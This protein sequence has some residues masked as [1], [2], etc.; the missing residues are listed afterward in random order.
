MGWGRHASSNRVAINSVV[1]AVR[2]MGLLN[3]G[4]T[5]CCVVRTVSV[6]RLLIS[7]LVICLWLNSAFFKTKTVRCTGSAART[8]S[9]LNSLKKGG[10]RIG[11]ALNEDKEQNK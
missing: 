7:R 10:V 4:I 5:G 2:T 11:Q 8:A 1:R 3:L 6:V 9:H